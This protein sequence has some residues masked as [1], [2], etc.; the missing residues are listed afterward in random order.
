MTDV[1]AN[2]PEGVLLTSPDGLIEFANPAFCRRF[3]LADDPTGRTVMEAIRI[4]QANEWIERLRVESSVVQ[5]E[6][7]LPGL[8]QRLGLGLGL[9]LPL[10]LRDA[11]HLSW[12]VSERREQRGR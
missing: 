4:H 1:F 10:W 7:T 11:P 2:M 3:G 9:R 5:E 6:F 12:V 8:D